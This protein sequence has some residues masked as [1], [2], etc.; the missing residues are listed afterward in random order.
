LKYK[1]GLNKTNSPLGYNVS[2][3]NVFFLFAIPVPEAP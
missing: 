2:E 3:E 1:T